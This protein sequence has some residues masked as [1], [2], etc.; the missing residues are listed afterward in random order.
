MS[1]EKCLVVQHE[2]NGKRV[3]LRRA[4]PKE[5]MATQGAYGVGINMGGMTSSYGAISGFGGCMGINDMAA[6]TGPYMSAYS[7]G[8]MGAY[9]QDYIIRPRLLA[10]KAANR[11]SPY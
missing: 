1:V 9:Q 6:M 8:G 4:V 11:F 10:P 7:M 2:L 5:Q 3:D